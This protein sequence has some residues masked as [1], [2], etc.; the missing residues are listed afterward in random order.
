MRDACQLFVP[1]ANNSVLWS[2]Q[3]HDGASAP[4]GP[5][6]AG[7][8]TP[9]L[10]AAT[11]PLPPPAAQAR[12][13][14]NLFEPPDTGE[15]RNRWLANPLT[16]DPEAGAAHERRR[17]DGERLR[18]EAEARRCAIAEREARR[19]ML[20]AKCAL[21]QQA[22][23][24]WDTGQPQRGTSP[25]RSLDGFRCMYILDC[26]VIFCRISTATCMIGKQAGRAENRSS[27]FSCHIAESHA[28]SGFRRARRRELRRGTGNSAT[29][30]E[31]E[32]VSA[33]EET[34]TEQRFSC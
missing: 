25:A 19:D 34:Q 1:S 20:F 4:A 15:A 30:K 24:T 13:A 32:T 3:A 12:T 11:P 5:G 9:G 8:K 28:L 7:T 22:V 27:V 23:P 26:P 21:P 16:L 29:A 6:P 10:G 18:R 14:L 33:S 31:A 2:M 17:L